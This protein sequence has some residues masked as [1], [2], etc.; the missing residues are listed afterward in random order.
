[1]TDDE[2]AAAEIAK[3]LG[4][5]VTHHR[6]IDKERFNAVITELKRLIR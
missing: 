3:L 1:M 5:T 4:M 6:D 2:K